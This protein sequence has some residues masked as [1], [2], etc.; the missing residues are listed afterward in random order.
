MKR[1]RKTQTQAAVKDKKPARQ[2]RLVQQTLATA[3]ATAG[4]GSSAAAAPSATEQQLPAPG[5]TPQLHELRVVSVRQALRGSGFSGT[6]E[7]QYAGWAVFNLTSKSQDAGMV[8]LSPFYCHNGIPVPGLPGR[9]AS[10]VERIWQCLKVFE[11]APEDLASLSK[12]GMKG[13]KRTSRKNG[14]VLGHVW[15]GGGS[16]GSGG[17]GGDGGSGGNNGRAGAGGSGT[18]SGGGSPGAQRQLLPYVQARQRIYL[19]AYSWVLQHMTQP[20]LKRIAQ[21]ALQQPVALLDYETNCDVGDAS[22]PLSHASLVAAYVREHW[23]SLV[24]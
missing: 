24:S 16:G 12:Q 23:R 21:A 18:S 6:F 7:R 4:G 11:G 22:R 14:K 8:Q 2:R 1:K 19:P 20:Q 9:T 15:F 13:V 5:A 17:S 10:S 3:A